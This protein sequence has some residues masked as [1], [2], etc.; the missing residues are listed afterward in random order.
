M[1]P[2]EPY[3]ETWTWQDDP[4]SS[5]AYQGQVRWSLT[6]SLPGMA[7]RTTPLDLSSH[8]K[9]KWVLEYSYRLKTVM[10]SCGV[11][12]CPPMISILDFFK[13]VW[14][15]KI[16]TRK[17]WPCI[18]WWGFE[19]RKAWMYSIDYNQQSPFSQLRDIQGDDSQ[20]WKSTKCAR[21]I[22]FVYLYLYVNTSSEILLEIY[23]FDEKNLRNNGCDS[24]K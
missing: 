5:R 20:S 23:V 15:K 18:F 22:C 13:V 11:V 3:K 19:K 12:A 4:G 8:I 21:G 9:R 24:K 7:P 16:F 14:D 17:P 6:H 1:S 2:R 10:I